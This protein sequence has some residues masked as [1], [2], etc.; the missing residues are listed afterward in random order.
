[1][2]QKNRTSQCAVISRLYIS[3]CASRCRLNRPYSCMVI[4]RNVDGK[5]Q[6]VCSEMQWK[7]SDIILWHSVVTPSPPRSILIS[8]F[9]LLPP[10]EIC[11]RCSSLKTSA[12]DLKVLHNEQNGFSS[13]S[14]WVFRILTDVRW[15]IIYSLFI[16]SADIDPRRS[17]R[18]DGKSISLRQGDANTLQ[19]GLRP[20][21]VNSRHVVYD[22]D[23]AS[24]TWTRK[25]QIWEIWW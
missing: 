10:T 1:M 12:V 22:V 20:A 18:S 5:V 2:A 16:I 6:K 14:S 11:T 3:K 19:R 23:T 7:V 24:W 4:C 25:R 21:T 13:R 9:L 8:H 17:K 15:T